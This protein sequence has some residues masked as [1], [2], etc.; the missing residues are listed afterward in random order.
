ML[1][2]AVFPLGGDPD[3]L[4]G[5]H[6]FCASGQP[7]ENLS[8]MNKFFHATSCNATPNAAEDRSESKKN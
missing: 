3:R 7:E 5:L 2:L 6:F 8:S 4:C 1:Q